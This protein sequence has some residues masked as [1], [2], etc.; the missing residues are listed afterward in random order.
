MWFHL[1]GLCSDVP[2]VAHTSMH[3]QEGKPKV[4]KPV[5][6][7]LGCVTPFIICPGGHWTDADM[8]FHAT[9]VVSGLANNAGG[10]PVTDAE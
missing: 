8:A 9:S 7:E 6:A 4:Q 10:R 3:L 1:L 2:T 5:G